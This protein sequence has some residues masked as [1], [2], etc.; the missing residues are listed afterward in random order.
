[1]GSDMLWYRGQ[2]QEVIGGYVKVQI[3]YINHAAGCLTSYSLANGFNN[4]LGKTN[5]QTIKHIYSGR[6]YCT[7]QFCRLLDITFRCIL[8]TICIPF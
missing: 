4:L 3:F 2:V 8:E 6:K 7:L 5:C 1:M